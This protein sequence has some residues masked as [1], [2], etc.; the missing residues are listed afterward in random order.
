MG[1]RDGRDDKEESR[2][3]VR[4]GGGELVF[5]IISRFLICQV[6]MLHWGQGI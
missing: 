6:V 4:V 5:R 3:R 1:G 2:Q